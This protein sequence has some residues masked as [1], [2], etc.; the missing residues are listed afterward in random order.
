MTMHNLNRVEAQIIRMDR[1]IPAPRYA[2][3]GSAG[4]DIFSPYLDDHNLAPGTSHKFETKL[5]IWTNDPNFALI[6]V[7]RSGLGSKGMQLKNTLGVIDADYQGEIIL[8]VFNNNDEYGDWLTIPGHSKGL[9][10]AQILCVPVYQLKL[11]EVEEFNAVTERGAGG[12]G[13]TDIK[14]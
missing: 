10:F 13:S 3:D 4:L 8:N 11:T 5:K 9:P 6:A 14:G 12:F 7:P 1:N 2:T